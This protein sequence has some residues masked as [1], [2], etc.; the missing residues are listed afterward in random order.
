MTKGKGC[1]IFYCD[2]SMNTEGNSMTL[3]IIF[4]FKVI[5]PEQFRLTLVSPPHFVLYQFKLCGGAKEIT[6]KTAKWVIFSVS[7]K[8]LFVATFINIK[9]FD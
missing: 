5:I 2:A 6:L 3:F 7:G 9:Y 1:I 8:A 4:R